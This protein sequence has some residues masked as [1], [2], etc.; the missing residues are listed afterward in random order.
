MRRKEAGGNQTTEDKKIKIRDIILPF[1]IYFVVHDLAS[2]LL[3]FLMG[4][5]L[6][7][8]GEGYRKFMTDHTASVN[9]VLNGLAL[10][11]GALSVW[12]MARR[13][14]WQEK[15]KQSNA[16]GRE[17]LAYFLLI[18]CAVS[19]AVGMNLLLTFAGLTELS[20]N[21]TEISA[22]QYGVAFGLGLVLY[23]VVSPLAEEIVFRGLIY[24][25]MKRYL[26]T[27]LAILSCGVLFG[28]YHGNLVQGIYGCVLGTVITLIYEWY[29]RI[30]APVLFHGAANVAVFV[31]SYDTQVFQRMV[32]PLNGALFLMLSVLCGVFIRR[33]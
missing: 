27:G 15:Q 24:H 20:E 6:N 23:G 21:Y 11:I 3:A 16:G 14:L 4:I 1:L 22:R 30:W 18:L 17:V 7:S 29:G 19:L 12:P 13:E 31:I 10:C 25:R 32:T 2:I 9:G 8:F 5:S 26:K 28:V 33:H